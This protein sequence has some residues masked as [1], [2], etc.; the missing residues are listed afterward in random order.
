MLYCPLCTDLQNTLGNIFLL[1]LSYGIIPV[2]GISQNHMCFLFFQALL[3]FVDVAVE[4][5]L[6]EWECL[7]PAQ[8]NLYRDVMLENYA[9]LVSLGLAVSKPDLITCLEQRSEPWKVRKY[10]AVAKY[11]GSDFFFSFLF[12]GLKIFFPIFLPKT[13][14]VIK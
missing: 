6:E 10:I 1:K 2:S 8:Q 3:T 13:S 12:D 5:S 7:D 4:F 11:P 9:N 14:N